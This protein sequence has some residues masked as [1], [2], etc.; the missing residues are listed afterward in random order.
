MTHRANY[1][2]LPILEHL[3]P[4]EDSL[5]VDWAEFVGERTTRHEFTVPVADVRDVY[6]ELQVYEV[7]DF[8]HEIVLNGDPLTGFDIPPGDGWQYWMDS[9]GEASLQ[10]GT[11]SLQ[12]L[13][14]RSG[15][16]AFAVGNAVVN[17]RDPVG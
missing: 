14:D 3:G 12:I 9:L 16:D 1:A 11:N 5:S 2:L 10:T 17:W 13:R 4:T 15:D 7:G 6:V 8:G